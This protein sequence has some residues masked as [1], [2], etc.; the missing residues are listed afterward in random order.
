M[1][2]CWDSSGLDDCHVGLGQVS[3]GWDTNGTLTA[4]MG[5][6]KVEMQIQEGWGASEKEPALYI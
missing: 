4:V 5:G 2:H 3:Q 1:S 6:K